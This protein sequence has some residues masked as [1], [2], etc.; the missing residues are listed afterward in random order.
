MNKWLQKLQ[1]Q[2]DELALR[3][4]GLAFLAGTT[5]LF[6]LWNLFL[7]APQ[8][9]EREALNQQMQTVQRRLDVQTQEASVLASLIGTGTDVRKM[10]QLA[11]L[12]KENATLN[13]KLSSLAV[14][15]VPADDLLNVLQDVLQQ[16]S[17]LT[18]KRIEA[19]PPEELKLTSA[20]GGETIKGVINH[21]VVLSLECSYFGLLHYMQDLE[22]LLWRFNWNSLN[23][24]V[25]GYPLGNIELRVSTLTLEEVFFEN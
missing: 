2:I 19:L 18:I 25:S 11:E 15:L 14:G 13:S 7:F 10:Q 12:E 24:R 16:S 22:E 5:V 20:A 17:K 3:E 8:R 23:Y 9:E 21:A 4:R 1:T 6:M